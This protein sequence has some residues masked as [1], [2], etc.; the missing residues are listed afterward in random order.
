[1]IPTNV[2]IAVFNL[3]QAKFPVNLNSTLPSGG[4][5]ALFA[6]IT[7]ADFTWDIRGEISFGI[8]PE[9]LASLAQQ[10]N[11]DGQEALD[12]Y[13]QKTAKEIEVMILKALSS[14]NS[15][16]ERLEK[17][18]SG[19]PDV[20]LE[21][22]INAGFPEIRDF[23]LSIHSAK[24]PDFILYRQIRLLYEEFLE[25]QREYVSAAFGRRAENHIETQLRFGE[26]E[27]YGELLTKY[28]VLLEYLAMQNK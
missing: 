8:D 22:E 11:L 16:D 25:K 13:M 24:Y 12:E 3:E 18:M 27:Q 15:N 9:M 14:A 6:G 23:S 20:Q 26:L 7:N 5:Y 28:P 2:H 10:N 21:Q 1:L 19:N 4:N 17:I